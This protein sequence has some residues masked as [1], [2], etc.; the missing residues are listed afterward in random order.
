MVKLF[1][2]PCGL[3]KYRIIDDLFHPKPSLASRTIAGV[4]KS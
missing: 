2:E 4:E 1:E 3:I